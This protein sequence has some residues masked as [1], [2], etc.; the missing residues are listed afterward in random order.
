M[1][2]RFSILIT[3]CISELAIADGAKE[4]A[5][6]FAGEPDNYVMQSVYAAIPGHGLLPLLAVVFVAAV[7]II[8]IRRNN[9]HKL[10]PIYRGKPIN[11]A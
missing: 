2:K 7:T 4:A 1:I 3:S 6:E 5:M 10:L 11:G 9:N 8:F